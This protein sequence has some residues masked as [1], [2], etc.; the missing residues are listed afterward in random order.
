[1]GGKFQNKLILIFCTPM[2]PSAHIIHGCSF[3]TLKNCVRM[4]CSAVNTVS[5]RKAESLKTPV[6]WIKRSAVYK[7][8]S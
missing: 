7:K 8:V 2:P 1:M 4:K 6:P 5:M 3:P